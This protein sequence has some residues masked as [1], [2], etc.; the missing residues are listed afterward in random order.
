MTNIL[1]KTKNQKYIGFKAEG[2]TGFAAHGKDIV[3]AA[4]SVLTQNTVNA[5]EYFIG[6]DNL[7]IKIDEG[8]LE[9]NLDAAMAQETEHDA[10]ILIQALYLGLINL[11]DTYP[12]HLEVVKQEVDSNVEN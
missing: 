12:K 7:E 6:L 3:C 8:N 10:Q 2:H 11:E 4:V 9:V 1:F 5:L